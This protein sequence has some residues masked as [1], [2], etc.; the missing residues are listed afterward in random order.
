MIGSFCFK[1]KYNFSKEHDDQEKDDFE[2][3]I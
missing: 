1:G 3:E 2:I